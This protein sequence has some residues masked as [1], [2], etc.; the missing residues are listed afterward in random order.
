MD[1]A[2]R[3]LL[4]EA[5]LALRDPLSR[6]AM[7]ASGAPRFVSPEEGARHA[8]LVQQALADADARI[9]EIAAA[10]AAEPPKPTEPSS[11]CRADFALACRR[12]AVAARARGVALEVLAPSE[13]IAGDAGSVRRAALRMLRAACDWAG[14]EGRVRIELSRA[15]DAPALCCSGAR[16]AAAPTRSAPLRELLTRF[17]LAEGVRVEGLDSLASDA[18]AL[19]LTLPSVRRAA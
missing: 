9:E 13:A 15:G 19:A 6:I 2:L 1:A 10:L 17:A 7:A 14:A 18:L 12:A 16:S 11:D 3:A 4:R 8:E 5:L